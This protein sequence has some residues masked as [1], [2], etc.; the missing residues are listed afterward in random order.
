VGAFA[1]GVKRERAGEGFEVVVV[2][3]HGRAGL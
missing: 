2:L 3:A 1:H